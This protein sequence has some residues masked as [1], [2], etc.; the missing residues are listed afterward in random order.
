MNPLPWLLIAVAVAAYALTR[1]A[2]RVG[3]RMGVL[4]APRPGEV[5]VRV[6]PRT[7]G[8]AVLAGL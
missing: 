5:Q 6:V 4:D 2:E 8:Y 1:V 7:G 3:R